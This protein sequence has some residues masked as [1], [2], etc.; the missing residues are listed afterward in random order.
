MKADNVYII[1][2][3]SQLDI[4]YSDDNFDPLDVTLFCDLAK[5]REKIVIPKFF[6]YNYYIIH[7][8]M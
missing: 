2:F 3:Y 4:L 5:V 7:S 6:F 1:S 8:K